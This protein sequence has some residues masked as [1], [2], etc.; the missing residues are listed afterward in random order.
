MFFYTHTVSVLAIKTVMVIARNLSNWR[1]IS[2]FGVHILST[3]GTLVEVWS[4]HKIDPLSP[5]SMTYNGLHKGP[6]WG[7]S[8]AGSQYVCIQCHVLGGYTLW[9]VATPWRCILICACSVDIQA[10][11]LISRRRWQSGRRNILLAIKSFKLSS[12]LRWIF[13]SYMKIWSPEQW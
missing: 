11:P 4:I 8:A 13:V 3:F 7:F 12:I 5:F 2:L 10:F 1:H 9:L 6:K